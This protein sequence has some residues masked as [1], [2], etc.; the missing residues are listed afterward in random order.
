MACFN[1]S[2]FKERNVGFKGDKEKGIPS[3][4]DYISN[5]AQIT[6]NLNQKNYIVYERTIL[7]KGTFYDFEPE[8]MGRKKYTKLVRFDRK[9]ASPDILQDSGDKKREPSKPKEKKSK[10]TKA[11]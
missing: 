11:K 7:G 5:L 6:A 3:S 2:K 4:I 10:P 1:G 8:F 9:F